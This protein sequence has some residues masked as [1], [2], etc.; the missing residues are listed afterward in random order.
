[1]FKQ[2]EIISK[3]NELLDKIECKLILNK[4][5]NYYEIYIITTSFYESEFNIITK[6]GNNFYTKEP[7][8]QNN[9]LINSF[10]YIKDWVPSC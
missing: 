7:D 2:Y 3:K 8:V 10:G 5:S 4:S 1:M 6:F 9:E